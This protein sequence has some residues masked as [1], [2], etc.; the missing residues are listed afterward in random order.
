MGGFE[1]SGAEVE[2]MEVAEVGLMAGGGGE[3]PI[4]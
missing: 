2:A 4:A 1:G 3:G